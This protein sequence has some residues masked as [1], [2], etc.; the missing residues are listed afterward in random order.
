MV[1]LFLPADQ[2]E[3]S[4]AKC[5]GCEVWEV[6]ER[7]FTV[8]FVRQ[9]F[10]IYIL[11]LW[12]FA[13]IYSRY[14]QAWPRFVVCQFR[15]SASYPVRRRWTD[16]CA[17]AQRR[18]W[19]LAAS[20]APVP[21]VGPP[22]C[23]E[24]PGPAGQGRQGPRTDVIETQARAPAGPGPRA[25]ERRTRGA[26]NFFRSAFNRRSTS[27]C[28][29]CK[30]A[31]SHSGYCIASKRPAVVMQVLSKQAQISNQRPARCNHI[32]EMQPALSQM[33]PIA[34]LSLVRHF[35]NDVGR[36]VRGEQWKLPAGYV[37]C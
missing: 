29:R 7:G 32:E 6:W 13:G 33:Q 18:S 37:L 10:M 27:R 5:L 12:T 4:C 25:Q 14:F 11:S 30:R 26:A 31:S 21:N 15:A 17:G 24:E 19:A 3:A 34:A 16:A 28:R 23:V 35:G 22:P 20:A 36:R 8:E 2:M 9:V 1:S